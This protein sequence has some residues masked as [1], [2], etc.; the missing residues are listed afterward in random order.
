[1]ERSPWQ[2]FHHCGPE[3]H[4]QHA[5]PRPPYLGLALK[6]G[7]SRNKIQEEHLLDFRHCQRYPEPW[8]YN[9]RVV[10]LTHA[11]LYSSPWGLQY[12]IASPPCCHL[13]NGI[14]C[15]TRSRCMLEWTEGML[16]DTLLSPQL[17]LSPCKPSWSSR[18][19]H[20]GAP[21]QISLVRMS[22]YGSVAWQ[23]LSQ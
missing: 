7:C 14:G 16:G 9:L 6:L 23:Q 2:L 3:G 1:M 18:T 22:K 11:C 4:Q 19:V 10:M 8:S 15:L 20:S 12:S 5:A 21:K 13:E 17:V